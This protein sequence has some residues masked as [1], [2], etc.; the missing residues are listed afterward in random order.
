MHVTMQ[1]H[2]ELFFRPFLLDKYDVMW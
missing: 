2:T 1:D